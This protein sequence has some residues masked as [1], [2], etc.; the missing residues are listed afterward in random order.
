MVHVLAEKFVWGV[1]V[2]ALMRR[3][4][5][6]LGQEPRRQKYGESALPGC[7]IWI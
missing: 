4:A 6:A 3:S 2:D 5:N 1:L 7:C